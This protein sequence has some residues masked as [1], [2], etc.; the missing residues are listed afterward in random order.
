LGS[1]EVSNYIILAAICAFAELL[2]MFYLAQ[3]PLRQY[4][5]K[6]HIPL[7]EGQPGIIGEV[8]LRAMRTNRF[9]GVTAVLFGVVLLVGLFARARTSV[10]PLDGVMLIA[11]V[12]I[13][14][15]GQEARVVSGLRPVELTY[16]AAL[17]RWLSG[18]W[19][20]ALI[21]GL[22]WIDLCLIAAQVWSP[23]GLSVGYMHVGL[24]G[25]VFVAL[26]IAAA[27]II[28][29]AK[30]DIMAQCASTAL[31]GLFVWMALKLPTLSGLEHVPWVAWVAAML[32][33][34]L[35]V[36]FGCER[37]R[38]LKTIRSVYVPK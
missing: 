36:S 2:C 6:I 37:R 33:I 25:V 28:V 5:E 35:I 14:T 38:W 30:D 3:R 29:P 31:Y 10:I 26:G 11:M 27:S 17:R 9:F 22:V 21:Y 16:Y 15:L 20:S 7:M 24:L 13:G 4:Y 34:S 19:L 1:G 32:G 18:T 23:H 12:L 8:P